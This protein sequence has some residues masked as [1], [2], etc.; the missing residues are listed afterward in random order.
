VFLKETIQKKSS[1][2]EMRVFLGP[3]GHKPFLTLLKISKYTVILLKLP[4]LS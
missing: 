2:S 4:I 1:D 3:A